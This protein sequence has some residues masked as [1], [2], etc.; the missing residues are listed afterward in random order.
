MVPHILRW[1][2]TIPTQSK[3]FLA[4]VLVSDIGGFVAVFRLEDTTDEVHFEFDDAECMTIRVPAK[5]WYLIVGRVVPFEQRHVEIAL[6][7]DYSEVSL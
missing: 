3:K 6:T 1:L 5:G 2:D 7:G 4:R